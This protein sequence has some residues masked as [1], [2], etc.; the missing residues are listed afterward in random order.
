MVPQKSGIMYVQGCWLSHEYA[1]ANCYQSFI[2]WNEHHVELITC[3]Q[4]MYIHF[5]LQPLRFIEALATQPDY[6]FKILVVGNSYV[7]KSSFLMR[8]CTNAFIQRYSS[9]IGMSLTQSLSQLV[10]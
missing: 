10:S 6:V 8:L 3:F 4:Y 2:F 7:G 9:T 1:L 5:L